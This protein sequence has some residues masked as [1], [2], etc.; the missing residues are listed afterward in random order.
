MATI[1][2]FEDL[3]I[4]N[5]ARDLLKEIIIISKSIDLKLDFKRS[6]KNCFGF[7]NGQDC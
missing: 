6:N 2:N 5:E 4:W 7:C 1:K 3:E